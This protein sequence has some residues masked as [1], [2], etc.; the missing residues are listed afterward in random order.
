MGVFSVRQYGIIEKSP[1]VPLCIDYLGQNVYA[2]SQNPVI[3]NRLVADPDMEVRVDHVKRTAEPLS[4]QDQSGRKV[5]YPAAGRVDLSA[6]N[7]LAQF[8]DSWL[9]T[10]LAQGFIRHQ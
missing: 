7:S 10:L 5:V 2:L 6:K 8:L 4:L 3:D 9:D 1:L